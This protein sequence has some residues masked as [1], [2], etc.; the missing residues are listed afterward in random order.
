M[1]YIVYKTTNKVNNFIYIGVHKTSYPETF[2]GYLGCGVRINKPST[3][4]NVK[5]AFQLAVK[6]FGVH[7]F[8]RETLA[9]FDHAEDAYLLEELLVN[10]QFLA[11]SDVYN[12]ILGGQQ[13]YAKGRVIN[14]YDIDTGKFI[15]SYTTCVQAAEEL[16]VS[17]QVISRAALSYYQV[18]GRCFSYIKADV[19]DTSLYINKN[20]AKNVYRYLKS[21]AFDCE[22]NSLSS[23]AQHTLDIS[24]GYAQKAAVFGYCIKD[25]YYLSFT[26]ESTF[27]IAKSK[28]IQNRSVYRYDKHGN[29]SKSYTTQKEAELD[30]KY[31]N[32]TKAVK[33]KTLD[34]NGWYWSLEKLPKFNVPIKKDN[35]KVAQLDDNNNILKTWDSVNQCA[36][37]VGTAVKN[38]LRGNYSKHKGYIY[39]Y[40]DIEKGVN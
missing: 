9:V 15:K 4:E 35:R 33:N 38:V 1:K 21:G 27:D 39:K 20:K 18:K 17:P 6:T 10:E 3:Y 36:K 28:Q 26:K 7:N 25:T 32:I 11:R 40:I 14:E 16:H 31:S 12:M 19:I 24:V 23:A 37:E 8:Y 2:D 29:F 5:T 34:V 22:F 30:N 13:N